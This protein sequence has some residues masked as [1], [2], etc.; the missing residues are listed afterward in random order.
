MFEAAVKSTIK[1]ETPFSIYF[2]FLMV[3]EFITKKFS[4][5]QN[6]HEAKVDKALPLNQSLSCE[7]ENTIRSDNYAHIERPPITL[8]NIMFSYHVDY[9]ITR[10]FLC[11]LAAGTLINIHTIRW[12]A[13]RQTL[14]S[15]I[16]R[17]DHIGTFIDP[18]KEPQPHFF[19]LA[20]IGMQFNNMI[21]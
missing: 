1:T 15:T 20:P 16:S 18:L 6:D 4:F 11:L 19:A 14:T 10:S 7:K 9:R 2:L 17:K 8:K 3:L 12:R 21:V 13:F 5:R